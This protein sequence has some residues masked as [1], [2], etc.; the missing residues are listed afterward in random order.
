M[1]YKLLQIAICKML[2][3][4]VG[5]LVYV[6]QIVMFILT[7]MNMLTRC[8]KGIGTENQIHQLL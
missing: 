1:Q 6:I 5:K 3:F 8:W 2:G 7:N 4:K